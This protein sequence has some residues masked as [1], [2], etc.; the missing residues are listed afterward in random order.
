[1]YVEQNLTHFDIASLIWAKLAHS[2]ILMEKCLTYIFSEFSEN[3]FLENLFLDC[4]L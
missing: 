4:Y 2:R 1:M 3:L